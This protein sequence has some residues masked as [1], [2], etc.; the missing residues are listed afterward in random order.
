LT[1]EES[2]TCKE[3]FA[4]LQKDCLSLTFS[5]IAAK[6]YAPFLQKTPVKVFTSIFFLVLLIIGIWGTAQVKDGLDLTDVVPRDS[7]E[8]HFL[9]NEAK[10][11]GFYNIYIV[12][13]D[14]DYPNNQRL[15]REFHHSF[16][17]VDKILRND[18]GKLPI[19]WLDE[20][21]SWLVGKISVSTNYF[22]RKLLY[23]LLYNFVL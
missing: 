23:N 19:S 22:L 21:R 20:F 5:S 2:V 15:L 18:G 16:Q 9:E 4:V 1:E 12:T 3:R 10:Y 14:F 6:K 13:K 17:N 7:S 8:Y 11:F